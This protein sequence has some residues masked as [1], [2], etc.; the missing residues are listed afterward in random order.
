MLTVQKLTLPR[1]NRVPADEGDFVSHFVESPSEGLSEVS[2]SEKDDVPRALTG[3]FVFVS[4][5]RHRG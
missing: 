4:Q 5:F 1:S 3:S 2:G